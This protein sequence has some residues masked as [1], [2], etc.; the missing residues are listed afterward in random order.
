MN[1]IALLSVPLLLAAAPVAA[2]AQPSAPSGRSGATVT[3]SAQDQSLLARGEYSGL[4]IGISGLAGTFVGFGVGQAV[5]GRY[6]HRGWIFT[7]GEAG[8]IGLMLGGMM[9]CASS[10][11]ESCSPALMIGGAVGLLAFR[12]WEVIDVWAAPFG[13]NRRVRAAR[14]R[15]QGGWSG[16][17][18]PTGGHSAAAGLALRF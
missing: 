9:R 14:A 11:G 1:R 18:M 2:R 4:E 5:Q 12:T 10:V 16:F 15:A 7:L 6:L 3:L 13:H 8:S 17:V